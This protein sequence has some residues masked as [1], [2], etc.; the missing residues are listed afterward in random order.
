MLWIKAVLSLEVLIYRRLQMWR[1]NDVIGRNEYLILH[2][3]IL[4]FLR[5]IHCNFCL[6]LYTSLIWKKMWVGVFFWTQCTDKPMQCAAI[7]LLIIRM[8]LGKMIV[9]PSRVSHAKYRTGKC[10]TRDF[11]FNWET[12]PVHGW[13]GSKSA[14]VSLICLHPSITVLFN[15]FR[16]YIT[17]AVTLTWKVARFKRL[18]YRSKQR[19]ALAALAPEQRCRVETPRRCHCFGWPKAARSQTDTADRHHIGL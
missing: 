1:H 7:T 8:F 17:H 9:M 19:P 3:Q 12:M 13:I 11:S 16:L 15:V 10:G 4:L 18:A 5:C 2:C 6:N 14:Q